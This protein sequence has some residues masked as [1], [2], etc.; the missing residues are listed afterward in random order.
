MKHWSIR[1]GKYSLLHW[2]KF[3]PQQKQCHSFKDEIPWVWMNRLGTWF[4]LVPSG[5]LANPP[6]RHFWRWFSFSPGGIC[7]FLARFFPLGKK[8]SDQTFEFTIHDL[9]QAWGWIY[10]SGRHP[11]PKFRVQI[12]PLKP[13]FF[14]SFLSSLIRKK[15]T[16][17]T[18]L[19]FPGDAGVTMR[20]RII[21][22]VLE[23]FVGKPWWFEPPYV[24]CPFVATPLKL[25]L[26]ESC[27]TQLHQFRCLEFHVLLKWEPPPK[28]IKK[29]AK[30]AN[31]N[32]ITRV[33]SLENQRTNTL[34]FFLDVLPVDRGDMTSWLMHRG[35][36]DPWTLLDPTDIGSSA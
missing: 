35:R 6:K 30:H 13:C 12:S 23:L 9:I 8:P 15:V 16:H 26:P 34:L 17:S 14:A 28:K 11:I 3:S 21:C 27:A 22:F 2:S 7:Q 25:R 33:S 19:D 20:H 18:L 36:S 24:P 1:W 32:N 10:Y 5:E 4:E 29:T 31:K